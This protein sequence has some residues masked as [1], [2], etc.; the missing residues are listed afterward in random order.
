[1]RRPYARSSRAALRGRAARVALALVLCGSALLQAR[2]A[3]SGEA[4]A[5]P[6]DPERDRAL[7]DARLAQMPAQRPGEVDLFALAF[8][9]DG[10]EDVF[11]NEAAYFEALSTARYGAAGRALA[12]VNHPDS[13]GRAPRPLATLDSLRHAL[14]GIAA[15]MD[16]DEDLLLLFLT[17]HGGR[18]HA[19]TVSQ[20]DRFDATLSPAQ[21]REALDATGIR[22]RLLIVSACFSGGFI[23]ALAAPDTLLITAARHDR[24]SFGCG[25]TASATY[26]GRALL[27]EGLNRDGGLLDA[28]AYARRQVARREL[29][30]GHEASFPQ[31]HVGER[32]RTR[33]QAWEASLVR[34]P[35]LP[36]PHPL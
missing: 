22:H 25:D 29:M 11:R 24:P 15:R 36:Y 3:S 23:P 16:R 10:H 30:E 28:F 2:A 14:D 20:P 31:I 7:I 27:V 18:D 4:G 1:M 34:G 9:G 33:L 26:F 5:P 19:L 13:L 8:A 35:P 21:L 32:I 17:S 12:L 6:P